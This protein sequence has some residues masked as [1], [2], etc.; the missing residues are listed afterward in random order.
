MLPRIML[1][2]KQ[3]PN[4]K[5]N[6]FKLCLANKLVWIICFYQQ[7]VI[8][9]DISYYSV[10]FRDL[11]FEWSQAKSPVFQFVHNVMLCQRAMNYVT[12]K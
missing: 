5:N 9:S 11:Q 10:F 6:Y 8:N 1:A 2:L 3:R 4:Q 12:Q 7:M